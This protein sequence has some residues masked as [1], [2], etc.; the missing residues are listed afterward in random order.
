MS[1]AQTQQQNGP[2]PHIRQNP[3]LRYIW[4]RMHVNNKNF[5][6]VFVGEPGDG[7]SWGALRLAE[8]LDPTFNV[9][10]VAFSVKELVERVN[11][12]QPP[13]DF[14]V[15]DEAGV[16]MN[17][18]TW[19]E[20][21]QIQLGNILETWRH[22]NRGLIFTLPVFEKL[23]KD[24]RG[25][26]QMLW[27]AYGIDRQRGA[28]KWRIQLVEQNN[29]TGEIYRPYP[30]LPNPETGAITKYKRFDMATPSKELREA[31]DARK[32]E[33]TSELNAGILEDLEEDEADGT[34]ETPKELAERIVSNER[35][36]EFVSVHGGNKQ[37]YLDWQ[38][39]RAEFGLSRNDAKT[40]KKLLE[41]DDRVSI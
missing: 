10:K 17:A 6:C 32:E 12:E 14:T 18:K 24:A 23:Q 31:Y 37:R 28:S 27:T 21:D 41:K 25:L 19:W 16:S 3:V 1:K 9:D 22:Q 11:E 26:V 15:M 34:E 39:L 8:L 38:L 2:P 33:Y 13:G 4:R 30:R 5:M 20:S 40:V 35:V 7:K 36:P 29:V